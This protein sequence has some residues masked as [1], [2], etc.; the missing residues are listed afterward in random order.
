MSVNETDRSHETFDGR[1]SQRRPSLKCAIVFISTVFVWLAFDLITKH[2][3]NAYKPGEL[4]AGPFFGIIDFRL[5]HNTGGAWGMFGDMT[6]LLGF[7]SVAVCIVIVV[8]LF[9]LAPKSPPVVFFALALVFVGGIG[10]AVDRFT[11]GYVVDFIETVFMEFPV[12]NIADIGVTCGVVI[13]LITM[14]VQLL[15]ASDERT[16]DVSDG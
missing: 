14:V 9:V 6:Q 8:Y 4:I 3:A 16:E 13:F 15:H 12:F 2:L 11:L 10:N 5:V 1:L 7:V